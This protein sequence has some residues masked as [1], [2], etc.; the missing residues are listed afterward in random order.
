MEA[1]DAVDTVFVDMLRSLHPHQ[2]QEYVCGLSSAREVAR[3]GDGHG[4]FDQ[5]VGITVA[6]YKG[7]YAQ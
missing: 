6:I 4:S 5:L 3:G 2:L 7:M 1:L